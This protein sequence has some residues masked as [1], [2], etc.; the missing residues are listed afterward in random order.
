MAKKNGTIWKILGIAISLVIIGVGIVVGYTR[1]EEQVADNTI[2]VMTNVALIDVNTEHRHRFEEK[3]ANIERDV[4]LIL[5]EV[6][7]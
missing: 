2:D 6:R 7:K 4:A 1:L 5:V 3:V